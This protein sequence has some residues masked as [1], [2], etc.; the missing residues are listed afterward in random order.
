MAHPPTQPPSWPE[1]LQR[2]LPGQPEELRSA[3]RG[4]T[5]GRLTLV[6][7]ALA[8]IAVG[9]LTGVLLK[10]STS[11]AAATTG[12]AARSGVGGQG[13]GGQGGEGRFFPGGGAGGNATQGTISSVTSDGFVMT[14]SSGDRV[15]VT[16][17]PRTIVQLSLTGATS[18]ALAAGQQVVVVGTESQGKIAATDVRE[19]ALGRFGPGGRAG[20]GQGGTGGQNGGGNA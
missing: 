7:G 14:T 3:P 17:G 4:S 19:G 8:L 1:P 2:P 5:P 16:V 13:G 10:S 11:P 9:I 6:L 18:G 20:G 12:A 15:T